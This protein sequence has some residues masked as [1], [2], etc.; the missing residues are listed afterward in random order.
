[1]AAHRAAGQSTFIHWR[2]GTNGPTA[3]YAVQSTTN[4]EIGPWATTGSAPRAEGLNIW[5]NPEPADVKRY[6]RILS[7]R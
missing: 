6:Y 4:L 5:T 3:P 2:G 7:P 1:M